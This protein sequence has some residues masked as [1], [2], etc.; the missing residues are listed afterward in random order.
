MGSEAVNQAV[1]STFEQMAFLDVS[2]G[3]T[4]VALTEGPVLF[5]AYTQPVAGDFSLFLPKELKFQ[6]AEAI[7]GEN[8]HQLSTTQLDDSLLELMNVLVG[9]ILSAHFGPQ[10]T[11]A[12]GLPTVLYDPPIS[13]KGCHREEFCFHRDEI[14]FTLVW[15]EVRP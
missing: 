10:T 3:G 7:Y 6:V 8:W 11:Y 4:G 12:M 2:P 9:R 5:L 15:N 13:P 1:V 14:A